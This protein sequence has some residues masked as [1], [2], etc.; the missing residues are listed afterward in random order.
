VSDQL[1]AVIAGVGDGLG[2][3]IARRFAKAGHHVVLAA[4]NEER[5]QGIADDIQEQGGSATVH[6]TDLREQDQ[7]VGLFD[8]AAAL[9][10]IDVAVFNA[11]AQHRQEFLEIDPVML[12]KV[13]RLG[14]YAG[15]VTG[16]EAAKRMVPHGKGSIL[17]TGAT[18]SVRGGA[19]FSTFSSS[20]AGLRAITQSMARA[21]GSKGIHVCHIIVDGMIDMPAIRERF[22]D[23]VK[24]M[25]EDGL[26]NTDA[27]AE[28]Y[29]AVHCQHRSAWTLEL[30]VRPYSENF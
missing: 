21:L 19:L 30:D 24:D 1:V 18:A 17:F 25:P 10:R 7:I 8:T 14:C 9:G 15:F 2:G 4:R 29:Y 20:K 6:V 11:G 27:I 26:L 13:W 12:E 22:P 3:A 5:L 23:V 28:T 16:Q